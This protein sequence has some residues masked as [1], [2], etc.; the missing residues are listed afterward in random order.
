MTSGPR[1]E[2]EARARLTNEI[3]GSDG[4]GAVDEIERVIVGVAGHVIHQV[5]QGDAV[6]ASPIIFR[7][8]VVHRIACSARGSGGGHR[9][10][11]DPKPNSVESSTGAGDSLSDDRI[12]SPPGFST[13]ATVA[14]TPPLLEISC[15]IARRP[16]RRIA[17]DLRSAMAARTAAVQTPAANMP[18]H[19]AVARICVDTNLSLNI[20]A[21]PQL[22]R[23][24]QKECE[25]TEVDGY[26]E[27]A[28]TPY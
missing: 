5:E 8:P 2:I 1:L 14:P 26:Q 13:T 24:S 16:M 4:F 7:D 17:H 10:V 21:A 3:V 9:F 20:A 6:R 15:S 11:M 12:P 18:R 23:R 27:S 25:R 19:T 22:Q 28:W